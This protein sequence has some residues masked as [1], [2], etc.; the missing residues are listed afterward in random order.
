MNSHSKISSLVYVIALTQ[1]AM[2]FMFS[3]V[4]ITLPLMGVE[5]HASAVALGLVEPG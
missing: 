1:F 2:P 3:G 4:G 5:L